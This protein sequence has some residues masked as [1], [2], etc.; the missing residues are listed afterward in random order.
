V[1]LHVGT[2]ILS[3]AIASVLWLMAHGTSKIE[4]G[5]D[6]PIV[7]TG[8]PNDLV[9]TD[10]SADVVNIRVLGTRAALRNIGPGNQE[11][12]IDVSGA[13]PGPLIH[14]VD[15]SAI[16]MPRGAQIT[17]RSPAVV[18][19]QFERRGRKSVRIRPDVV[20]EPAPGF[21]I[22]SIEVEPPH[23]WLT[24]ARRDVLRLSEVS[25]EVIDISGIATP[26]EKEARLMLE[27]NHVW[28][29]TQGS[30]KVRVQVVP[31]EGK[32]TGG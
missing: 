28:R 20:G 27:E 1:R 25:T 29:E 8:V 5:V 15:P 10:K 7:F 30:I 16:E 11:Y 3:F 23:V 2:L 21:A 9:I 12:K 31:V 22:A 4:R 6:I 26:L 24:G 19:V 13:K 32:A 18:E 14:E 17:S